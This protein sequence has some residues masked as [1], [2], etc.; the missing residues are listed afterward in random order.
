[1]ENELTKWS[2][3]AAVGKENSLILTVFLLFGQTSDA[4]DIT[5]AKRMNPEETSQSQQIHVES[6]SEF[7]WILALMHT[8]VPWYPKDALNLWDRTTNQIFR[9]TKIFHLSFSYKLSL[10]RGGNKALPALWLMEKPARQIS[11]LFPCED[12]LPT[13]SV[14]ACQKALRNG[15]S[16]WCSGPPVEALVAMN[17]VD[18]YQ[19]TKNWLSWINLNLS[20]LSLLSLRNYRFIHSIFFCQ[21]DWQERS[22]ATS[23][24]P[25]F[26]S[27][28]PYFSGWVSPKE[29]K[30]NQSS[31]NTV[32]WRIQRIHRRP[33]K[34]TG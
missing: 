5:Y 27:P 21:S 12:H 8:F 22:S 14:T 3:D 1:M 4:K 18:G 24:P 23:P 2:R 31:M 6:D 10:P 9:T 28:F 25:S 7:A 33:W 29:A 13:P 15:S 17:Q 30:S 34:H 32:D 20:G 19:K 11:I 26:E 16:H